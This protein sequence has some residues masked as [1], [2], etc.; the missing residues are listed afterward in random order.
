MT[1]AMIANADLV[2]GMTEAHVQARQMRPPGTT[3]VE[4]VDPDGDIEDPIGQGQD[5]Y[6]RVADRLDRVLPI[7]LQRLLEPR[8]P[9]AGG[10]GR[11]STATTPRPEGWTRG[12]PPR[13]NDVNERIGRMRLALDATIADD[14]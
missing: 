4:R 14:R 7:R 3:P 9:T 10:R 11:D 6:D 1:P 2:L 13:M 5:I 8:R 12:R